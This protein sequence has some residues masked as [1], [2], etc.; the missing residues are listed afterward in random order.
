[1]RHWKNYTVGAVLTCFSLLTMADDAWQLDGKL[2][3]GIW[4]SNRSLDNHEIIFPATVALKGKANLSDDIALVADGR[5]GDTAYFAGEKNAVAREFYLD[6]RQNDWDVRLGKQILPW[7][8]ADR[9]N[10]TDSLTSRDYRWLAPEE[11][12]SRFGNTG[13]RYNYHLSDYTLTGVWLPSM[14]T[15]R[16]PLGTPYQSF[17]EIKQP[18]NLDNF[19]IKLDYTG[20]AIDAALSFYSGVDTSP[21]LESNP[22]IAK[23]YALLNRRIQRYGG[24]MAYGMGT[25]TLRAEVAYTQTGKTDNEFSG[26]KYNYVQSVMGIEK[27]FANSMNI[28]LQV[29]W[30]SALDWHGAG[31]W[32]SPIQQQLTVFEQIINQQPTENYFGV[33][34]RASK[35]YFNDTL[36]LEISGLGLSQNQGLMT[37]PRVRYQI[38]DEWTVA[39]GG[40]YYD[41]QT[42][43]IFGRLKGNNTMFI[44]TNYNFGI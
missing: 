31:Y 28:N 23:P 22:S 20:A 36:E 39:V 37:R 17:V 10:P 32:Q 30:Q 11:E 15:T 3:T 5:M 38:S 44:E 12:D 7:G 9:I 33:A 1:M 35:K 42:N 16:I 24:D 21:T 27:Q 25:Y 41:G 4:S 26:K 29:V 2:Q 40:D 14:S 34:Y 18:N 8:R 13:I 19:A 6:Y 43:S